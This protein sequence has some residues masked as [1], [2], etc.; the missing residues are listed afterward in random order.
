MNKNVVFLVLI[1]ALFI[2]S[3]SDKEQNDSDEDYN[4]SGI[5]FE[6]YKG[7]LIAGS[8]TPYLRYSKEDF[9]KARSEGKVI[10]LYFYAT[11]CP[12]CAAERPSIFET[13]E[14]I[15]YGDVIGFEVHFNDPKTTKEDEDLARELGVS[16]QHTTIIFD[17][18]GNE[19]YRSLS[20]INKNKIKEEISKLT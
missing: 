1:L 3:C 13:F 18:D 19:A 20:K 8:K 17:K 14:E 7:E 12:I 15:D 9:D 5:K 6:D 16:Y 4:D 11:W 10:Y 2:S